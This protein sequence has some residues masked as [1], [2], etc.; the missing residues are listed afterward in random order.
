MR[1][2]HAA[3]GV[4]LAATAALYLWGL[5]ASGWANGF[6]SAAAQAGSV[7]WKAWF[8]GSSD[9]ANWITVDKTPAAL[10]VDGLAVRIFGLSSWSILVPQALMGVATVALL[11]AGVRRTAQAAELSERLGTGAALLAGAALAVTPVAVL[12]F[13]FNNPDALLTLL[14]VGSA[15]ATLRAVERGGTRWLVLA[16]TLVGFGFLAKMLQA[17]LVLPALALVWLLV[18]PVGWGR[19]L[20]D[21]ALATVALIVSAGWWVLVVELWPAADRPF[22]GGSQTN[23][24]LELVLGYNGFGRLTGD[25][26]GSVGGG[27]G[28]GW[29]QT[30]LTRLFGAEFGGQ[31]AWLL[32]AALIAFG[33]LLWWTRRARR[34]DAVRAATLLWGGWLIVTGLTFSLM[35]GIIHPYYAVV[36]APPIAALVGLG[37]AVLWRDRAQLAARLVLAALVAASA[38]EAYVLLRRTPQWLP[39]TAWTVVALGVLAVAGLLVAHR[40]PR[41]LGAGIVAAAVLAGLAGPG[42]YAVATAATAHTGAVP[43]AGPSGGMGPGGF[44]GGQFGGGFGGARGGA[45]GGQFGPPGGRFAPGTGGATTGSSGRNGGGAASGRGATGSPGRN[46]GPGGFGGLLSTPTPSA[47]VVALLQ[48]DASSFTWAAAAVGS[49]T[50]AGYQLAGGLPVMAVGG[51]NGTDPS[52]TLA[53][54]EQLVAQNKIH[55]FVGGAGADSTQSGGSDDAAQIAQWVQE[56]Y[57]P[58]TVGGSTLYDLSAGAAR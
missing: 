5:A 19:R 33:A 35:A 44:G 34:T 57:A 55:W 37:G 12:I 42:G 24:A 2:R 54:F 47:Q 20:R 46:G 25:E 41:V 3:L 16:A 31:V 7:S 17:F 38:C 52:P 58:T 11:Y 39:W 6:Y 8:F 10:W 1:P 28:R 32:P 48:R 27:A 56:H 53:Q 45:R 50:A 4:L 51:F 9:A 43:S 14:L 36:L 21:L 40:G 22:I 18:A 15:Y 30:G 23:S 26:V 13:R 29:G 49:N